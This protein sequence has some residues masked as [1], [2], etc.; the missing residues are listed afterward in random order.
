MKLTEKIKICEKYEGETEAIKAIKRWIESDLG[1]WSSQ[2]NIFFSVTHKPK[3]DGKNKFDSYMSYSFNK[4]AI[5]IAR[6]I[7]QCDCIDEKER[8]NDI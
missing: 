4:D 2:F 8:T 7:Y 5:K 3:P 1:V 6:L